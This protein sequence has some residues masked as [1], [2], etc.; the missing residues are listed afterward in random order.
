MATLRREGGDGLAGK[1]LNASRAA[2]RSKGFRWG[3]GLIAALLL[4]LFVGSYFLDEPLRESVER[5]MNARLKGYFV[6]LPGLHLQ[7]VGLSLT[8]KGLSVYQTANPDPPIARFP[9]LQFDIHWRALLRGKLVG[10]VEA[11][12]PEVRIDLRQLRTEVASPVPIR[13]H[14]WQHAVAAIYPFKI[15][16]LSIRDGTL[17]YI[18]KDPDRPLRL[19]RLNLEASNIRNVLSPDQVYPSSFR[20]ETA[21]FESGRGIVEGNANFLAEPHLGIN[22]RISLEDV[23]LEY[24]KPVVAR[25][26]LSVRSGTFSGSGRIEYAPDVKVTHLDNLTVTGM[27]IDYVHTART[28]EAEKRR[29]GEVGKAVKEAP[30]SEMDLRVDHLRLTKCNVGMVN[31]NARRP[32]RV[33]LTDADLRLTNLSNRFAQ[34]PAEMVLSGKFM[35]SGPAGVSARF[36]PEREGPDL[37]LA[38]KIE[39]TPLADMN[40]LFRA[41]GNFDV[42]EGMFA[43]YSELKVRNDEISGYIKPFFRNMK[44]Y[45]RR[46]DSQ[47]SQ[48]RKLYE[49]LVGGVSKLLESR[50]RGE[51]AAKADISG[52]VENPRMSNWQIVGKLIENAFFKAILPEFENVASKAERR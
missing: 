20:M 18:D 1:L 43:F 50:K 21:I 11:D 47:K 15:N 14:G 41:Y 17:T 22:A 2:R 27:D 3:I 34:G 8:L 24:F 38:V 42:T 29:A 39:N 26:N 32:Y 7:L 33:F 12:R 10:E 5:R 52:P 28:A 4:V 6:R 16:A 37:D 9:A 19:T 31:E 25:T 46:D 35:G 40:D 45:D 51:V 36:R 23:A 30:K 49:M 13:E 44:V 48:F